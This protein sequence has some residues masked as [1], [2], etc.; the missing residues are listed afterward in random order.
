[1][2]RDRTDYLATELER[3]ATELR[4]GEAR[5]HGYRIDR[6]PTERERGAI[7]YSGGWLE[8]EFDHPD[9]W[10]DPASE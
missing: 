7:A 4:D 6:D 8:F 9:G 2:Q 10:F 3:V 1:M 5:L